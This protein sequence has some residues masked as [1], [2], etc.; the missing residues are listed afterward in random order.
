MA[1][2]CWEHKRNSL[3]ASA[4]H[5]TIHARAPADDEW[6]LTEDQRSVYDNSQQI[7]SVK[8]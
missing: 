3:L 6:W 5:R 4:K 7:R 1:L 8:K 2:P